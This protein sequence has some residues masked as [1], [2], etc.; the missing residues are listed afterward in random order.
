MP[1]RDPL[2]RLREVV[3][4]ATPGEWEIQ[5]GCSWRRIGTPGN[6]GNVLC[7]YNSPTDNH[8]DLCAGRGE[9][10]YDNLRAIITGHRLA[11]AVA[12]PDFKELVGDTIDRMQEHRSP[13]DITTEVFSLLAQTA[14]GDQ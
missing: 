13:E 10:T 6:N 1:D 4:A 11:R 2:G 12:D 9:S 7:P 5:D 14:L 8:P 3:G